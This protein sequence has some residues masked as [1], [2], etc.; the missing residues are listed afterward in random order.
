[1]TPNADR[2]YEVLYGVSQQLARL[3]TIEAT[4]DSVL[5]LASE[6]L[7]LQNAILIN[8]RHSIARIVV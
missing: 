4:L 8:A 7:P 3:E 5:R 1:M 6:T 2:R